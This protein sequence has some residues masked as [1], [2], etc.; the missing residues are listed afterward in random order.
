VEGE[1]DPAVAP[2]YRYAEMAYRLLR[3]LVDNPQ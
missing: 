2:P 1:Q 3:K